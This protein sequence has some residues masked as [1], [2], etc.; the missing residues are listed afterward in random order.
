M[1]KNNHLNIIDDQVGSP[2]YA[3]DLANVIICI[4]N[5]RKWIPGIYH[6]SNEGEVSW[7]EFAKTIKRIF[8]YKTVLKPISSIEY[9]TPAKRPYYS[10]LDKSKIKNTYNIKVPS[11]EKS[12]TK[13]IKLLKNEK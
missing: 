3:R 9:L 6:Y 12:L 10:L 5:Y 11:F 7:Y 13:C 2:T 8:G 1:K 4:I